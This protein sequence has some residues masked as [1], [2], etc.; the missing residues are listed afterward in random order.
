M[1]SADDVLLA[2][3]DL[4]A[5]LEPEAR[6]LALEALV[7][8]AQEALRAKK[9]GTDARAPRDALRGLFVGRPAA[10]DKLAAQIDRALGATVPA[11]IEG[12]AGTGKTLVAALIHQ[13]RGEGALARA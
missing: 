12:E 6:R 2:A 10:L 5:A 1:T 13:A 8:R 7:A 9:K 4:A 11:L 3:A